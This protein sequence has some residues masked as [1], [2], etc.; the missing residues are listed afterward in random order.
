MSI[1]RTYND[2]LVKIGPEESAAIVLE[3]CVKVKAQARA[4]APVAKG[5][6]KGSIDYEVKKA[7]GFVG[8]PVEY[9]IYQEFGTRNIAPQPYLRPAIAS[10]V[11]NQATE[12]VLAKRAEEVSK[13]N[14]SK[15]GE[16]VKFF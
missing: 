8:S 9:A 11:Y 5:R 12:S 1:K 2:A 16:R 7:E 6:L 4:L 10:V 14:L 15:G 3:L 13:G